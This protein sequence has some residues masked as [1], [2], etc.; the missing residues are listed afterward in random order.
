MSSVKVFFVLQSFIAHQRLVIYTHLCPNSGCQNFQR[1]DSL[2]HPPPLYQLWISQ[3]SWSVAS[4]PQSPHQCG[5]TE[6]S[7]Y[8]RVKRYWT[9]YPGEL[10]LVLSTSHPCASV[11]KESCPT[12]LLSL[13]SCASPCDPGSTL[14]LYFKSQTLDLFPQFLP[15]CLPSLLSFLSSRQFSCVWLTG[16]TKSLCSCGWSWISDSPASISQMLGL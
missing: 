13:Y 9:S 1:L 7:L 5:V 15:S 3:S 4:S 10:V 16:M 2:A 12:G 14:E 6:L 8:F 11:Y